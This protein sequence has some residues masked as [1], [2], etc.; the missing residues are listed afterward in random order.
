MASLAQRTDLTAWIDRSLNYLTASWTTIPE[1]TSGWD[2]RDELERLDFVM[3]WQI[4]EDRL[5]RIQ[6]WNAEGLLSSA[7]QERL[8]TLQQL[9]D[10]HRAA[11]DRLLA[12]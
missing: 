7:Q 5:T 11:L 12:E 3:E 9:I 8:A 10:R 1:V 4:R 6:Q 2:A